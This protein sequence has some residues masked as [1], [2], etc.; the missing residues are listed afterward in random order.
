MLKDSRFV[1]PEF[2][3]F[4]NVPSEEGNGDNTNRHF[5]NDI[6]AR[7]SKVGL[8]KLGHF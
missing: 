4:T 3:L 1:E 8:S 6:E 2:D 7:F 5:I